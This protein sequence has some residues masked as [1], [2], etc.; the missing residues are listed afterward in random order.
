MW[1]CS[2]CSCN[3]G[4]SGGSGGGSGGS[5][6]G[7]GSG[8]SDDGDDDDD[9]LTISNGPGVGTGIFF[10]Y[11][12]VKKNSKA[13]LGYLFTKILKKRSL[14]PSQGHWKFFQKCFEIIAKMSHPL[15]LW[16]C[17]YPWD[18]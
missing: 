14:C 4:G 11:I 7:G 18:P 2:C 10:S 5:G 16:S 13:A 8:G 9:K 15:F 6:G 17:S 3:S 1:C 12:F